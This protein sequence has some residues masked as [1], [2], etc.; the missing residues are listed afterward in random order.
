[1]LYA[2]AEVYD[3]M[4]TF[5]IWETLKKIWVPIALIIKTIYAKSVDIVKNSFNTAFDAK[6]F[7]IISFF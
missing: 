7:N 2:V 4:K 3:E 6:N 5:D 1:M